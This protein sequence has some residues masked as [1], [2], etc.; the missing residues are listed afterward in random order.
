MGRRADRGMKS[1]EREGCLRSKVH[2]IAGVSGRTEIV[3]V[4]KIGSKSM[5]PFPQVVKTLRR[6]MDNIKKRSN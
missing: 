3:I 4:I 6:K 2:G 5:T 1:T